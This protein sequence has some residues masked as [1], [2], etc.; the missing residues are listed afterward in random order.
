M[1]STTSERTVA[2]SSPNEPS[3]R[4]GPITRH[5]SSAFSKPCIAGAR[6]GKLSKAAQNKWRCS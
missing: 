3:E 6:Q 2:N 5:A 1:G 4:N